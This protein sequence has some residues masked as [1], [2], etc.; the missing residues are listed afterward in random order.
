M[1]VDTQAPGR[2]PR[3]REERLVAREIVDRLRERYLVGPHALGSERK[4]AEHLKLPYQ[5]VNAWFRGALPDTATLRHIALL[6]GWNLNFLLL[7][8]DNGKEPQLRWD[9]PVGHHLDEEALLRDY[10][11][12][13]VERYLLW[14]LRNSQARLRDVEAD[15][16]P[17]TRYRPR[18]QAT[19]GKPRS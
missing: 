3:S 5:T 11:K 13:E 12:K 17:L 6:D 16:P 2:K 15:M 14:R 8:P 18:K 10:A 4:L 7:G 9:I 1:A 19:R